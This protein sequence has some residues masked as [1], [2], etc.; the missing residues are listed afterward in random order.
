MYKA[1]AESNNCNYVQLADLV[2]VDGREYSVNNTNMWRDNTG[3]WHNGY[4]SMAA[5]Q[6]G[7][8][9]WNLNKQYSSADITC[10]IPN[11]G[12]GDTSITVNVYGDNVLLDSKEMLNKTSDSYV[13]PSDIDLSDIKLLKIEV[14]NESD[15]YDTYGYLV[16]SRLYL[17]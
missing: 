4:I 5:D 15:E 7:F 12:G 11:C 6:G 3:C 14:V 16:D 9:V 13:F 2:P 8:A 1:D 17:K 10:A